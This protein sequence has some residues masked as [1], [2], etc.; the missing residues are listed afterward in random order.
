MKVRASTHTP[1]ILLI[2]PISKYKA[3]S[4]GNSKHFLNVISRT[5]ITGSPSDNRKCVTSFYKGHVFD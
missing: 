5:K 2:I 4:H 1:S 3:I